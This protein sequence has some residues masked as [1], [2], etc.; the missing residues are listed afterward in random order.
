MEAAK[1]QLDARPKEVVV[2]AKVKLI[3]RAKLLHDLVRQAKVAHLS[4][5]Y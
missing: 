1:S 2:K 4:I 5:W 3:W